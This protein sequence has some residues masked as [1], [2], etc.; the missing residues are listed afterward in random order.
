M[1]RGEIVIVET[2]VG[3]KEFIKLIRWAKAE[4]RTVEER[5]KQSYSNSPVVLR[6][7]TEEFYN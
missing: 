4:A 6:F 2:G 3:L 1:R 5:T 7:V